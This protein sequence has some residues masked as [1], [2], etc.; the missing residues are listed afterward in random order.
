MIY[1]YESASRLSLYIRDSNYCYNLNHQITRPRIIQPA[2][3][4]RSLHYGRVNNGGDKKGTKNR[5]CQH[6]KP[7]P[8]NLCGKVDF[9]HLKVL[10][11]ERKKM[12]KDALRIPVKKKVVLVRGSRS[13]K[14][15]VVALLQRFYDPLGGKILLNGWAIYKL[16][17]KYTGWPGHGDGSHN[18]LM[19]NPNE[20]YTSLVRLQQ[21][22][23]PLKVMTSSTPTISL[24][25]HNNNNDS[26]S[27]NSSIPNMRAGEE[28][29]SS[30]YI[31]EM[32]EQTKTYYLCFVALS[33]FSLLV[34]LNQ[35]Y[36]FAVM[37]EN[38]TKRERDGV[39]KDT[40][41]TK[42]AIVVRSLV[43]DRMSLLVQTLSVVI[44]SGTMG[45]VISW[46]LVVVMIAVQ[47][48]MIISHYTR[49]VLLKSMSAKAIKA[50]EESSKLATKFVS[51][52]RTITVF[53]FQ[54]RILK[55]LMI[56]QQ[57]PLKESVRQA[58][59][60]GIDL[61]TSQSLKGYQCDFGFSI[62]TDAKKSTTLVGHS[63]SSKSTI[64][65]L[66]KRFY[67]P[68]KGIVKLDG[69]DIKIFHLRVL[70]KHIALVHQ[71]PIL[72]VAP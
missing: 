23:Q 47:P 21:T 25:L 65:G 31:P 6:G 32:Q 49:L 35:H 62:N 69:K 26:T 22:D 33:V 71:E 17:L 34:N 46:R 41:L 61:G 10:T 51:N 45:L 52:L 43:G 59:I 50:Q 60:A 11:L 54:A 15:T 24:D 14:S 4:V 36:N 58:W 13:G 5:F 39:F 2:I 66:I 72:F 44:I 8:E 16:Q 20:L 12:M 56:A 27:L 1:P 55:M 18:Q 28:V 40:E 64:N 42:D 3:L 53:S 67:D 70:R 68:L 57:G 30:S 19:Q 48:I 9:K 7:N 63:G 29:V 37:R 38:L